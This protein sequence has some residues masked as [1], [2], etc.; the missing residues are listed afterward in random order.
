MSDSRQAF[1][2]SINDWAGP[3]RNIRLYPRTKQSSVLLYSGQSG[4]NEKIHFVIPVPNQ[5]PFYGLKHL[6]D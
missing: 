1:S 3:K 4:E 2:F 5:M 6:C